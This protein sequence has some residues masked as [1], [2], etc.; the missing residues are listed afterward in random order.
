[1]LCEKDVEVSTDDMEL[2]TSIG[3]QI[4]EIVANA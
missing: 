3:S 1:L 2:L 4:S